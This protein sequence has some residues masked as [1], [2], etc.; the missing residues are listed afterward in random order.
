MSLHL[1]IFDH[2]PD[3]GK[4]VW[5]VETSKFEVEFL[6]WKYWLMSL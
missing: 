6:Q 2:K 5:R 4:A 3:V 1:I